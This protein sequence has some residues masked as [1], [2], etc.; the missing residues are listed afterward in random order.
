MSQQGDKGCPISKAPPN[1]SSFCP[2][3]KDTLALS[4]VVYRIEPIA[5]TVQTKAAMAESFKYQNKHLQCF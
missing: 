3:S 4:F 1:A 5:G 2:Y